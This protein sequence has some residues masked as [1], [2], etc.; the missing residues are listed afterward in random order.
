MKCINADGEWIWI[1]CYG[2]ATGA[3]MDDMRMEMTIQASS[4][5]R[6]WEII[7]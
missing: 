3:S 1:D 6:L 4:F 7:F 2:L 5:P